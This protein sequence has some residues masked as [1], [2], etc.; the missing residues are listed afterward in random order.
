M[1]SWCRRTII[2]F[3]RRTRHSMSACY[4]WWR[5]NG[6]NRN[7]H[8]IYENWKQSTKTVGQIVCGFGRIHSM[9]CQIILPI[10]I[11][12]NGA[13]LL[14]LYNWTMTNDNY[15]MVFGLFINQL[16]HILQYTINKYSHFLF[17]VEI[18]SMKKHC[19]VNFFSVHYDVVSDQMSWFR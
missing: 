18:K 12:Q 6:N 2:P 7:I 11:N 1:E 5:N 15:L 14:L 13:L 16:L 4:L 9:N 10:S 17:A 3:T 8:I 19:H